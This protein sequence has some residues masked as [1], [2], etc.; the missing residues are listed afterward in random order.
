MMAEKKAEIS[1][2][3]AEKPKKTSTVTT[4][5]CSSAVSQPSNSLDDG[6]MRIL[7]EIQGDQKSYDRKVDSIM[8]RIKALEEYNYMYEP[9]YDYSDENYDE[10]L[11]YEEGDMSV[12]GPDLS[13]RKFDESSP[14]ASMA[15][16]ARGLEVTGEDIE[17]CLAHNLNELFKEGMEEEQYQFMV[18]DDNI[19]RPGNC[20]ALSTVKVNRVVWDIISTNSKFID[21]RFQ[22]AETALIK[23]SIVIA[24]LADDLVKLE[25]SLQD[26]GK[27]T[28][29]IE[30]CKD[31]LSLFGHSN[32]LINLGR[33]EAL[34]PDIKEYK[35]LCN[36]TVPI[37]SQLFGDDLSQTIKEIDEG[38][39]IGNK[40]RPTYTEQRGRGRGT[41]FRGRPFRGRVRGFIRTAID[42][43]TGGYQT[44][45]NF[46][47]RGARGMFKN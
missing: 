17:P 32:R 45:K 4:E 11:N 35:Y 12:S 18:K 22:N 24:R 31:A 20:E 40:I 9:Q 26:S 47:R 27:V 2:A 41:G 46:S 23:G 30:K 34:K 13:K 3:K 19:P 8:D 15:K 39:K 28:P 37:T 16:R 10:S 38:A 1:K 7:K 29:L 44:S 21:K 33:R 25:S 14:F 36:P 42:T 5:K 43:G 6:I